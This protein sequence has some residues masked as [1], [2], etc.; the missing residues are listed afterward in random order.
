[1]LFS[2]VGFTVP[3]SSCIIHHNP[4]QQHFKQKG[5]F[6]KKKLKSVFFSSVSH[7]WNVRSIKDD[8]KCCNFYLTSLLSEEAWKRQQQD[9]ADWNLG[10]LFICIFFCQFHLRENTTATFFFVCVLFLKTTYLGKEKQNCCTK[11]RKV[12]KMIW[13]LV[14]LG[15]L[16][17][18]RDFL[19]GMTD[20][21]LVF[22][23]MLQLQEDFLQLP[24]GAFWVGWIS[25]CFLF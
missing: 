21:F 6:K 9:P 16:Q 7:I 20:I 17:Y 3:H 25:D 11:I 12:V 10:D 1:M 22:C 15:F 14:T 5:T 23:T 8:K 18:S 4:I 13:P 2:A 19:H 24:A